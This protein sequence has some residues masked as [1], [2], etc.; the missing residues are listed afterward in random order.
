[1]TDVTSETGDTKD[2][3]IESVNPE[4]QAK[5]IIEKKEL[6]IS[7]EDLQEQEELEELWKIAG[8]PRRL[9]MEDYHAGAFGLYEDL[10]TEKEEAN[11]D[12]VTDLTDEEYLFCMVTYSSNFFYL[13]LC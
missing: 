2:K 3:R 6:E 13:F 4:K 12:I 7:E 8:G 9:T 5:V 11:S 1:M 10:D